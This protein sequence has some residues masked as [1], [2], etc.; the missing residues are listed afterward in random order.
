MDVLDA[1]QSEDVLDAQQSVD[2]LDVQRCTFSFTIRHKLGGDKTPSKQYL[3]S[4]Y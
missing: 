4:S 2:V 1:Q 3:V